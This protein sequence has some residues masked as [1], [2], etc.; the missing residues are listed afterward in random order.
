[1]NSPPRPLYPR[2]IYPVHIEQEAGWPQCWFRRLRK[3]SPRFRSRDRPAHSESL[4]RL[5]N[6][7]PLSSSRIFSILQ[8]LLTPSVSSSRPFCLCFVLWVLKDLKDV[9]E[10]LTKHTFQ[11]RYAVA[12]ILYICSDIARLQV[13]VVA[14]VCPVLYMEVYRGHT[15]EI[16]R[17]CVLIRRFVEKAVRYK[18]PSYW[19]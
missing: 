12:Y 5:H 2:I 7:S 17:L 18:I 15:Q 16:N 14:P 11:L 19:S 3:I 1:V 8:W 4:Y 10:S 9:V 6:P 13:C